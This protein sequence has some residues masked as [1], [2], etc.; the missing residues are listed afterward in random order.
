MAGKSASGGQEGQLERGGGRRK[1]RPDEVEVE[2]RCVRSARPVAGME[3][4][5][6]T[7]VS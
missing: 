4:S 2:V 5:A 6:T 7:A 3:W 1:T